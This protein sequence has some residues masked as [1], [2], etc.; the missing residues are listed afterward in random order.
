MSPPRNPHSSDPRA[1]AAA[2]KRNRTRRALLDAADAAFTARGWARTR[3]E[4]VATTA[5]VSPA[6]AYNHF[7]AKHALIA[8]VYA[9]LIAPL[10]A[11]EAAR[12]ANGDDDADP[13]TLVVEQIRALARVCVRNR[14]LTAAYWAAVQDYEVRVAAPPDPDDE[15]DPRT[16][17]P[18]AEVLHDLVERGQAAGE[19]RADPPA[20]TLCPILVD[21]LLARI[22]LHAGEAAEPVTRLVAGLALGVLAP[23]RVADGG[24]PA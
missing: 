7:P 24:A 23:E 13:A 22:A 15:Q 8:E 10:V 14:G 19:L 1:R 12:A 6:T 17:A 16:I 20:G 4:D 2:T 11:T 18:V 3:I 9:P 5:G 21:V